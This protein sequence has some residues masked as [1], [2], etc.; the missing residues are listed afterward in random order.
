MKRIICFLL[1]GLFISEAHIKA[2]TS[3]D[4]GGEISST[5]SWDLDKSRK[6]WSQTKFRLKLDHQVSDDVHAYI[7]LKMYD[8]EASQF[9]WKLS[10][11]YIDSYHILD[12]FDL[13]TG[14]QIFSWGTAY[15]LNPTDNLNPYDL[16]AQVAFIPE[17]RLGVTALQIKCYPITNLT[18]TGVLIPYFVPAVQPPGIE[19]PERKMKNSECA[20]KVAAQSLWGWDISASYFKGK[21]YYPWIN[22]QY[23]DLQIYG[24]DVIGTLWEIALW[25]EG[26]VT[27]P[28]VGDSFYQLA[29]GGE[30]TFGNDLYFMG[31]FYHRNYPEANENYLMAVSRYPFR[32]VHTLQ[33]GMAYETS[34]E[35]LI[36]FPEVTLSPAD[37]YSVILSAVKVFG[38]VTGTFMS[39]MKDRIFLKVEYSF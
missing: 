12:K 21:E 18:L 17:E 20:F 27:S 38:D 9:D 8:T 36:V 35:I 26:A 6:I 5:R 19:L 7:N 32:D 29:A 23:R 13:R 2:Q 14:V 37:S 24:G 30:Y 3:P 25:A 10:E 1:L 16:S 39:Q 31:Q 15:R 28:K 34:N 22:G 4:I 11:A 33:L